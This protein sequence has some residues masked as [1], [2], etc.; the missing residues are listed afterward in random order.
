MAAASKKQ[1]PHDLLSAIMRYLVIPQKEAQAPKRK[2]GE[3]EQR[4]S[5]KKDVLPLAEIEKCIDSII[6]ASSS[7]EGLMAAVKIRESESS[8]AYFISQKF[9]ERVNYRMKVSYRSI[10]NEEEI[11]VTISMESE[12]ASEEI[13]RKTSRRKEQKEYSFSIRRQRENQRPYDVSIAYSYEKGE[14]L[15][16]IEY[17]QKSYSRQFLEQKNDCTQRVLLKNLHLKPKNL[18]GG[19]LGYTFLG[20]NFMARRDDL[21]GSLKEE[22]DIHESIHTDHEYETRVLTWWIMEKAK[23]PYQGK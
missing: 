21:I 23:M 12:S 3:L 14:E 19:V 13:I 15:A 11:D 4:L 18:M 2:D 8:I 16:T 20:E 9:S 10:G 5:Q 7:Q 22:V 6:N 1:D 17:A